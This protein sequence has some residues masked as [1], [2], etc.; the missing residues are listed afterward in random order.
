MAI[1]KEAMSLSMRQELLSS[2]SFLNH[3]G[4]KIGN[5]EAY[6]FLL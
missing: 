1:I 5:N 2:A 4:Q 6:Q 3:E